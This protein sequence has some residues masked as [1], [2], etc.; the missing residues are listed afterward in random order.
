MDEK[1]VVYGPIDGNAFAIL[2]AVRTVL[3]KAGLNDQAGEY[4]KRAMSSDY[5]NLLLVSTEYVT[6]Q[7]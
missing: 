5:R 7:L 6:F 3:Q 2:G 4:T 1:P